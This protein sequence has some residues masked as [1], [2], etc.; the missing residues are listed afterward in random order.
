[1]DLNIYKDDG[2]LLVEN[3]DNIFW[4]MALDAKSVGRVFQVEA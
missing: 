3:S 1:M 4:I 2:V